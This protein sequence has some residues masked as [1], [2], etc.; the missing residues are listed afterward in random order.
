MAAT[1]GVIAVLL[2]GLRNGPAVT[3]SVSLHAF[4][5]YSLL[6]C[7]G[8]LALRVL[9]LVFRLDQPLI[10]TPAFPAWLVRL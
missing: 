10:R 4:L 3:R 9:V 1:T 2:L 5:G 7:A 6:V 8:V